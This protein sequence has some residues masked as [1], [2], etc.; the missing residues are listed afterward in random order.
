VAFLDTDQLIEVAVASEAAGYHGITLSD[1]VVFPE[2]LTSKYPYSADGAPR[3]DGETDWPDPW[4]AIGAMAAATERIRFTTNIFVASSRHPLLL[5]KQIATAHALSRGRVALGASAGW[6]REEF[7][8]LGIDF[9][10]RG[11]R[12]D[13]MV[14]VL[15]LLWSGDMV[16]HHGQFYDFDR[17]QMR[18]TPKS[19]GN[20]PIRVLAGGHSEPALRRAARLDGWI[21]NA[22]K[23][24]DAIPYLD[25]L[26]DYRNQAGNGRADRDDYQIIL[27]LIAWP[28]KELCDQFAERGVT[29]LLSAPW[30]IYPDKPIT[31]AINLFA[32][33]IGLG[34]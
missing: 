34:S 30:Q 28:D 7:D 4:V 6:M 13:E 5:A 18:P 24:D 3:W 17:V 9:A 16:E 1:H 29:G 11:R 32:E 26:D 20:N 23:P 27:G 8:L 19:D 21:G 2:E 14:D 25:R 33:Q 12:L 22:Y 10:S 15:R 31:D